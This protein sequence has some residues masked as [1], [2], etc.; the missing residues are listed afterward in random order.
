MAFK[1]LGAFWSYSLN[2]IQMYLK[3]IVLVD[4]IIVEE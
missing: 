2:W 1:I 4:G 3:N